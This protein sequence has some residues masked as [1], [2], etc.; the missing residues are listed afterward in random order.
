MLVP[1]RHVNCMYLPTFNPIHSVGGKLRA[2]M[3]ERADHQSLCNKGTGRRQPEWS[4]L[5]SDH[6]DHHGL[7]KHILFVFVLCN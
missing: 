6:E 7:C 5:T 2:T 3:D 4:E 1:A